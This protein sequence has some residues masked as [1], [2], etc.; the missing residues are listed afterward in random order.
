[1]MIQDES[2]HVASL[3]K[4]G[5]SFIINIAVFNVLIIII[6][7]SQVTQWTYPMK[8]DFNR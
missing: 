3:Q 2:K 7:L 1:M 5:H 4:Q 6:L 8:N